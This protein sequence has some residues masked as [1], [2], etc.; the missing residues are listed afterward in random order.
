MKSN[1]AHS[2]WWIPFIVV[3][4]LLSYVGCTNLH[5]AQFYYTRN[6]LAKLLF[7]PNQIEY[8]ILNLIRNARKSIYISLYSLENKIIHEALAEAFYRGIDVQMTTE[9]DEEKN[10]SWQYL[11]QA[12]VPIRSGNFSGI[13]HNKYFIFDE[14]YVVTGSA[15]LSKHMFTQMNHMVTLKNRILAKE[16]KKDFTLQRE[17]FFSTQ[18]DQA[19]RDIIL[20]GKEG[21]WHIPPINVSSFSIQP[22]FTP[23]K[24]TLY[25]DSNNQLGLPV[26]QQTCIKLDNC[27]KQS[28]CTTRMCYE[29]KKQHV[30]YRYY[31]FDSKKHQCVA[32]DNALK[33]ILDLIRKAKKSIVFIAFS[34]R[35]RAIIQELI[36]AQN[37]RGVEVKLWID[38]SQYRSGYKLSRRSMDALAKN[39]TSVKLCEPPFKGGLL[40]HK[41]IMIDNNL[42]VLGSMNF[43]QNAVTKNDENFIIIQ[44]A[45]SLVHHFQKEIENIDRYSVSLNILEN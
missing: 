27:E 42:L 43:S 32:Y 25:Q 4:W 5:E 22:Y 6:T 41:V 31:N 11:H 24:N 44:N 45:Y 33:V 39:V 21:A 18:K 23:Y 1:I 36:D 2:L 8:E 17:G 15:N 37:I 40:H 38:H 34:F 26:C 9:L 16:Y 12:H 35:D 7:D 29:P 3:T 30:Y 28:K 14:E 13:M 20:E 19:Y 10:S